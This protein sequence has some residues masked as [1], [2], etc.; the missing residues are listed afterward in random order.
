MQRSTLKKIGGPMRHRDILIVT[1]A[2][3]ASWT[4]VGRAFYILLLA[5]WPAA[6]RVALPIC[7]GVYALAWDIIARPSSTRRE[8]I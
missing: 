5:L 2:W 7:I 1:L 8:K 3:C 4:G 6:P